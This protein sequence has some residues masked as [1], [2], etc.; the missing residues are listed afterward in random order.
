MSTGIDCSLSQKNMVCLISQLTLG[1]QSDGI[2]L[3]YGPKM[4]TQPF[5]ITKE[6]FYSMISEW[7]S[8]INRHESASVFNLTKR[9]QMYRVGQFLEEVGFLRKNILNYNDLQ[10]LVLNLST[11]AYDRVEDLEQFIKHNRSANKKRLVLFIVNADALLIENAEFIKALNNLTLDNF[12]YSLIY[13]FEHPLTTTKALSKWSSFASLYQNLLIVPLPGKKD[14]KQ[15]LHY[16]SVRSQ[17]Q[18]PEVPKEEILQK[19]GGRLWFV[20]EA[21]RYYART[22]D[23]EHLFDHQE[24][25]MKLKTV[26]S[27]Y[28]TEE[29]R[30]LE[31]IV[32]GESIFTKTENEILSYFQAAGLVVT[33]KSYAL[34]I[35]LLADYIRKQS[36]SERKLQIGEDGKLFLA[37]V[38]LLSYFSLREEMLLKLLMHNG[39][40]ITSRESVSKILW[41]QKTELSYL[42]WSLDQALRRLRKKLEK[43]SCGETI[44]TIKSQG[45]VWKEKDE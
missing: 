45:Y 22:K 1:C 7:V 5:A 14:Q 26:L 34:S 28:T 4:V 20:S 3:Y 6:T 35:P 15:F 13:F 10:F 36:Y 27:E 9:T 18:L 21:V 40:K 29:H 33:G 23:T 41:D 17:L 2:V 31:K 19:C 24:M 39:V 44:H 38:P 11:L 25:Q 30:V 12:H 8:A 32:L 16:A 43:L 37:T 42:D